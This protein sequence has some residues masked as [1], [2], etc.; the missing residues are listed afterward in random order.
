[1]GMRNGGG[2]GMAPQGGMANIP[3]GPRGGPG[4]GPAGTGAPPPGGGSPAQGVSPVNGP[5]PQRTGR[6][7]HNYHP[8]AR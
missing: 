8:Y 3:R 7:Q 5:G 6:G 2:G 4:A 1:M